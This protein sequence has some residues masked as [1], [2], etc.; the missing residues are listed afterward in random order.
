MM[1]VPWCSLG[2]KKNAKLGTQLCPWFCSAASKVHLYSTCTR[3]SIDCC[4]VHIHFSKWNIH[5][6]HCHILQMEVKDREGTYCCRQGCL[7]HN[8]HRQHL[9]L[10][11]KISKEPIILQEEAAAGSREHARLQP[12]KSGANIAQNNTEHFF[13][14]I[15]LSKLVIILLI[16]FI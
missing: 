12:M 11:K 1:S 4:L 13:T 5:R 6:E 2:R 16:Y 8:I 9:C 15:I 7:D 14:D 3:Q 10:T